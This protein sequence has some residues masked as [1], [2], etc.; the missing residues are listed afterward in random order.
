MIKYKQTLK[1][2]DLEGTIIDCWNNPKPINYHLKIMLSGTK[3][4]IFSFALCNKEDKIKFDDLIKSD[5]EFLFD[6]TLISNILIDEVTKNIAEKNNNKLYDYKD[7]IEYRH[8]L[9]KKDIFL[10]YIKLKNIRDSEIYL[11]D[12]SV[13][14]G[15]VLDIEF[16]NKICFIQV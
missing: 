3:W 5:L 9:G 4:N 14:T 8:F 6:C 16:N 10:Q 15:I 1:F 12:D 7:I 11:I 2:I 13:N